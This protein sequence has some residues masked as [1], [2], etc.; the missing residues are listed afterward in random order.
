MDDASSLRAL[1]TASD[2]VTA[3]Q[4]RH[5]IVTIAA[6]RAAALVDADAA[7]V[8]L[9]DAD[10]QATIAACVGL[11][12]EQ[13]RLFRAPMDE[14]I[15]AALKNASGLRSDDWTLAVP[16]FEA[17]QLRGVLVAARR[18]GR[19]PVPARSDKDASYLL[20]A[21]ADRTAAA[22]ANVARIARMTSELAAADAARR[23]L[24]VVLDTAPTGIIILEGEEGHITYTNDRAAELY[25][26]P[27]ID[28]RIADRIRWL[29]RA[30]GSPCPTGEVP[31][32]RALR[33]GARVKGE[34]LIIE[35]PDGR[36]R[37]VEMHAVPLPDPSGGDARAL[38][39]VQDVTR[40]KHAEEHVTRR[41][42]EMTAIFKALPDLYFRVDADGTILDAR[43][44]RQRSTA[45]ARLI[46]RRLEHAVTPAALHH[47]QA[48]IEKVKQLRSLVTTEYREPAADEVRWYEARVIPL[49]P[50]EF[51]LMIRDITD[52]KR[53][54]EH[55]EDVLRVITHDLRAPLSVIVGRA[56]LLAHAFAGQASH[57]LERRSA[58]AIV[59]CGRTMSAMLDELLES[60]QLDAG[61][62]RL[63][64]RELS[65][66]AFVT[67]L[68][69]R[70][71]G[72]DAPRVVVRV[73]DG[74]P[75]VS[76]DPARLERVLCNLLTNALKYSPPDAPITVSAEL[77]G[78]ELVVS[79]ADRGA[80]IA[81]EDLPHVF[82]R[83]WRAN[84]AR[85][86]EGLGLGLFITKRLVEAHGGRIWVESRLGEG[87]IFRFTLPV[88]RAA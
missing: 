9:S 71:A 62:I 49:P 35:Q 43:S 26:R 68:I 16:M 57:E 4:S 67:E 65:V 77:D 20:S 80:G 34:E 58:D 79:V 36:F 53:A 6:E 11:D 1:I 39:A 60:V 81:A 59:T 7:F 82:E 70:V 78:A 25:G 55:R 45:I 32:M 19:Q 29:R 31:T 42:A 18:A 85:E 27:L 87:S 74:L 17:Q 86:R 24:A 69:D 21:L 52:R 22:L 23:E 44:G 72:E 75:A 63:D 3:A 14:N 40:R 73:P 5:D 51:V 88:R 15:T 10:E 50:N 33:H 41:L 28:T 83:F 8:L 30:D 46:G 47:L 48:G 64:R 2:A 66:A 61:E 38:L 13:A 56:R 76:A 37:V 84:S 54:E 12:P